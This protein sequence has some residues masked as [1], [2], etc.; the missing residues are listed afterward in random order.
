[1][2]V[3][4]EG[5]FANWYDFFFDRVLKVIRQKNLKI[6]DSHQG[7]RIVDLG[8]G[9]GAQCRLLA[10]YGLNVTG[11]DLSEKMLQVAN[12][13][14]NHKTRYILGD[15]T[16]EL[17]P[18]EQ[19]DC[20]LISLVLHPNSLSN[21]QK[22]LT[23]AK[24]LTQNQGV[25]IITDYDIGIHFKGKLANSFIRI[26][27][28]CANSTHRKNYYEFMQQGGLESI[29]VQNNYTILDRYAFYQG[30]LKTCVI[31]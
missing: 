13:K 7:K 20:A 19:F 29:L 8:C 2:G 1:M 31:K 5:K 4:V 25:I 14:N 9:T 23:Q 15:I 30:A 12:R 21:I 28:S 6:I 22:I 26:I 3:S 11:V 27:E 18:N 10:D 24:R 17:F 16:T